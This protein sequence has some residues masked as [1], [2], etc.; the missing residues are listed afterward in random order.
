MYEQHKIEGRLR[1]H[2]CNGK[3]RIIRYSEPAFLA[4]VI[5]H[6]MRM[7][8]IFVCGLPGS[9]IFFHLISKMVKFFQKAIEQKYVFQISV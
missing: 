2:S 7:R 8:H 6:E 5:Q 1:Y 4:L 9:T 3:A